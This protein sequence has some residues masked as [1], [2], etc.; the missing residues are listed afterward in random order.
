MDIKYDV[1]KKDGAYVTATLTIP[2]DDF[3][4]SYNSLLR[5]ETEKTDIKG[6]RKGKVPT[7]ML[8]PQLRQMLKMG[9]IEKLIP[10]Y[11]SE[12]VNKE[13][14]ELMAP[15]EYVEFPDLTKEEDFKLKVRFTTMPDFKLGDMKKIKVKKEDSKV[16]KEEMDNTLNEMFDKSMIEDKGKAPNDNWAKKTGE[17]YKLEGVKDLK[18]LEKEIEKLLKVEKERIVKQNAEHEAINQAIK[19]SKI[20]V[21]KEAVEFESRE[22]EKSFLTELKNAQMTL[23]T[24]CKNNNTKIEQLRE[25]WEKDAREALEADAVLKL[26]GRTNEITVT[27]QELEDAIENIKKSRGEEIPEHVET[28]E[29]WRNN[30]RNVVMKQKA[31]RQLMD[32]IFKEKEEKSKKTK[33]K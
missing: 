5:K 27:Q 1:E 19:L 28:D 12:I 13:K 7:E 20:E 23:E 3:E 4:K 22:R 11:L 9:A 26:Y 14:I 16:K 32:G 10:E 30:I 33:K 6:F 31:Y 15:P 18:G 24:F 21:P 2:Y 29:I 25:L 17:A 8:D